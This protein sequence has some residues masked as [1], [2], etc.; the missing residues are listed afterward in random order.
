MQSTISI[1]LTELSRQEKLRLWMARTGVR[2]VDMAV[3][4]DVTPAAIGKL[5]KQAT[6]PEHRHRALVAFGVPADL[7]PAPLNVKS[8]PK[9]RVRCI[10]STA[11][12][13]VATA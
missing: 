5:C 13:P 4:L 8:G 12:S 11:P 3:A 2:F 6:M 1:N 7:L 10:S 9:P